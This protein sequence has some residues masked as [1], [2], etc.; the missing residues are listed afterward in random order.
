MNKFLR[1][2]VSIIPNGITR[3]VCE[4]M[5]VFLIRVFLKE[6]YLIIIATPATG[7]ERLGQVMQS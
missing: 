6:F 7:Q 5:Q 3:G 2:R 4:F 1:F